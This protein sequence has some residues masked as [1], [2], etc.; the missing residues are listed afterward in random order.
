MAQLS[1][2]AKDPLI[3][4][5]FTIEMQ[6]A[7]QGVFKSLEN[8]G[9]ENELTEYKASGPNGEQVVKYQPG[10]L[11]WNAVTLK[12]GVTDDMFF[13]D[14]RKKVELGDMADARKNGAF[15]MHDTKGQPVAR[16]EF[17]AAWPRSIKG[18]GADATSSDVAI[19]ELEIVAE[20]FTRVP[21]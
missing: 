9:S 2:N 6:D 17:V 21:V 8:I 4:A 15:V 14:W 19:E 5:F 3:A 11:K 16:W 10:L 13:W 7:V 12:Q 18:P 1:N 20:G